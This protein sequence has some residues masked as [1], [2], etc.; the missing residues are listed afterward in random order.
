M[1]VFHSSKELDKARE[2]CPVCHHTELVEG[3][4]RTT[5]LNYFTPRKTKFWT[6]KDSFV[7]TSAKMCTRCGAIIWFGDLA[8]LNSLEKKKATALT[9]SGEKG[10]AER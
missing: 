5:G 9:D 1:E 7:Q 4:V 10:D 6:L 3:K 8:K 2:I